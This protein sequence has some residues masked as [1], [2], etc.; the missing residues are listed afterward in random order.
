[1]HPCDVNKFVYNERSEKVNGLKFAI[2]TSII[3]KLLY[4]VGP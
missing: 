1:M 4:I 2:Y 3:N